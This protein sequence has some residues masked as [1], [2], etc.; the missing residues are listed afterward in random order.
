[1]P[2]TGPT[3]GAGRST[4][5]RRSSLSFCMPIA[6]GCA[7][8][9]RS[10]GP[11]TSTSPSGCSRPTRDL[12]TPRSPASARRHQALSLAALF[13]SVAAAV[14]RGRHG[15]AS[16]IVALDGT[17]MGGPAIA[18]GE[19]DGRVHRAARSKE[20]SPRPTRRT[21][22]RT[23]SSARHAATSR[24]P[25]SGAEP[26]AWRASS[27]HGP[28]STAEQDR[29]EAA[30]EDHLAERRAE[31]G[32]QSGGKLRGRKPKAPAERASHRDKKVNTTDPESCTMMNANGFVQGFNA[33]A[34]VS[35]D[36]VVVAAG[37]TNENNDADQLHPMIKATNRGPR[38]GR[39]PGAAPGALSRCR[40][41]QHRQPRGA[42]RPD[43]PDSYISTRNP[44]KNPAP[45]EVSEHPARAGASPIEQMDH[46]VSSK[47]GRDLYKKRQHIVEPVFGQIKDARGATK[48]HAQGQA[49]RRQRMEAALRDEQ[50]FEVVPPHQRGRRRHAL[51]TDRGPRADDLNSTPTAHAG[52]F[53]PRRLLTDGFSFRVGISAPSV[54]RPDGSTQQALLRPDPF[55][56][57]GHMR[58]DIREGGTFPDY[59]LTDQSGKRRSLS[60]LQGATRWCSTSPVAASIRGASVRSAIGRRLSLVPNR[61][62]L[63][64]PHLD[65]Q[66]AEHQ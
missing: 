63:V 32:R 20:C 1:M 49:S 57:G 9:A 37:V 54:L 11:V 33:Q 19:Q 61:V 25:S 36:Q 58:S 44:R 40:L 42:R 16:G 66:S 46:K 59:E 3:A 6:S 39:C 24:R 43:D 45:K 29:A 14:R 8:R 28:S 50:P 13:T 26:N 30:Y 52:P 38:S 55:K 27:R 64:G 51:G 7:R 53:W 12:I 4:T 34:V 41:L 23:P 2:P 18:A 10:S 15:Q 48:V 22:P 60:E 56:P 62:H 47:A 21:P 65:R 5:R 35:E 17:K 31:R